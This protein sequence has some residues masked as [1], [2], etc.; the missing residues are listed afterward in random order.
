LLQ[1]IEVI[2][3]SAT[4]VKDTIDLKLSGDGIPLTKSG[5]DFMMAN[6]ITG[7][8]PS[9][10]SLHQDGPGT[11]ASGI[12]VAMYSNTIENSGID[13]KVE[14]GFLTRS[15]YHSSQV[16]HMDQRSADHS[17]CSRNGDSQYLCP[18]RDYQD[19]KL[20]DKPIN[21]QTTRHV[22]SLEEDW[23]TR[24]IKPVKL[25]SHISG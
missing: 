7:A 24:D 19:A 1:G 17:P 12:M 8:H 15:K 10:A 22:D 5:I 2:L 11:E 6:G 13:S 20:E 9:K 16:S 14:N 23:F 4:G 21:G 3:K 25:E 18:E